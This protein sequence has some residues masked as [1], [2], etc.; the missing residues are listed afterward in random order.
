MDFLSRLLSFAILLLV[1]ALVLNHI[2]L[3]NV[4]TPLLYVALVLSFP[5]NYPR[6]MILLWCFMM[7][8]GIDMFSNTPGVAAA[9]M[10]FVGFLQP[11][12]L[13]LFMPRDSADDFSVAPSTVGFNS[14]LLYT[15]ILV[16]VYCLLFFTLEAFNFFNWLQWLLSIVGSTILT[17]I[18]ILA[19]ENLMKK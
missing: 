17:L 19:V 1:Q 10:T 11:Y 2:H 5:R 6:W 7:G 9:S 18:L 16:F 3:F 14:Y 4:A 15:S 12:L 13:Q 8:F